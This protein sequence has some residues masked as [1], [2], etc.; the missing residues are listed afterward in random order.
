[1]KLIKDQDANETFSIL[2]LVETV[3]GSQKKL[4]LQQINAEPFAC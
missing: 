4:V 3:D 1:M 2:E